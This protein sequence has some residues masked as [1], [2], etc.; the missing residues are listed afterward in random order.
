MNQVI[1]EQSTKEQRVAVKGEAIANAGRVHKT[2][3][4]GVYVVGSGNPRTP[5]KWYVVSF[6]SKEDRF[7]CTCPAW[8]HDS[9]ATAI[10]C[11]V[12]ACCYKEGNSG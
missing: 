2:R 6:D 12:L 7:V 9:N 10:C 1:Q 11:H 4:N 3:V 5:E 8:A